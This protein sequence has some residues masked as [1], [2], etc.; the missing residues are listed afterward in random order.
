MQFPWQHGETLSGLHGYYRS[1]LIGWEPHR[2]GVFCSWVEADWGKGWKRNPSLISV[3]ITWLS[4]DPDTRS[5]FTHRHAVWLIL[6]SLTHLVNWYVSHFR[7]YIHNDLFCIFCIIPA[8]MDRMLKVGDQSFSACWVSTCVTSKPRAPV[9][10]DI[11]ANSTQNAAG[12][13][14]WSLFH[15]L[16]AL[17]TC[18]LLWPEPPCSGNCLLCFSGTVEGWSQ[19]P[20]C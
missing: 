11:C 6:C 18:S 10:G 19:L 16:P 7:S 1:D 13:N 9:S 20:L 17:T 5:A 15:C 4:A 2:I 14:V 3:S 12:R 8:P